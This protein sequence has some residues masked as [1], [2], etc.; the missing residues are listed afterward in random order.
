MM[1]VHHV[2]ALA[3]VPSSFGWVVSAGPPPREP[4]GACW[5]PERKAFTA[6]CGPGNEM[7]GPARPTTKYHIMDS[8]CAGGDTDFPFYDEVHGVYHIMYQD[9][10]GGKHPTN[11]VIGH[12]V[13]RD[14]LHWSH[15]PVSVWHD[16][17]WDAFA[18]YTGSATIAGGKPFLIYPGIDSTHTF[19][20]AMAIPANHSDPFYTNWTKDKRV[21]FDVAANPIVRNTSDDPSTAW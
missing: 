4:H 9:A 11:T 1:A 5:S 18:I 3:T 19:N 8:S 6:P 13:S 21:G 17:T 16:H 10:V 7:C 15:M 12:A 20:L 14:F 2:L